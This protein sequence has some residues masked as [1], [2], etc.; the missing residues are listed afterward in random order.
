MSVYTVVFVG[1]TP[2]GGLIIGAVASAVSVTAALALGGAACVIVGG[3]GFAWL[4]RI[5]VR[6]PLAAGAGVT[7]SA[8]TDVAAG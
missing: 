4:H 5:R 1:S 7:S 6:G 3:I 8:A 2:L